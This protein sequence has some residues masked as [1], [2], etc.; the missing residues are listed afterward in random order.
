[1]AHAMVASLYEIEAARIALECSRR[2][3]VQA[4]AR[5]MLADHEKEDGKRA[6]FVYR[7]YQQPRI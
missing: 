3:D 5:A 6:A 7:R 1:M 4:F 2:E